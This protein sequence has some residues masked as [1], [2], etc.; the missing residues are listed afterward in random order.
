MKR[1]RASEIPNN[2]RPSAGKSLISQSK[3][4]PIRLINAYNIKSNI[5]IQYIDAE[6]KLLF[7]KPTDVAIGDATTK[8]SSINGTKIKDS[9][10][11][12]FE[13]EADNNKLESINNIPHALVKIFIFDVSILPQ[14]GHLYNN[15][16]YSFLTSGISPE[17]PQ[18]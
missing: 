12:N 11:F 16:P 10:I 13:T 17:Y 7:V 15:F 18:L 3:S 4:N 1:I 14:L 9:T 2:N 5:L 8:V 6:N